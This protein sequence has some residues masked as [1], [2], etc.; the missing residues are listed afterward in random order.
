MATAA[1]KTAR[2]EEHTLNSIQFK[3]LP[4]IKI[5][6]FK[7]GK[8]RQEQE[9]FIADKEKLLQKQAKFAK[10]EQ[11]V[12]NK[13]SRLNCKIKE[14]DLKHRRLATEEEEFLGRQSEYTVKREELQASVKQEYFEK[15][16]DLFPRLTL[17]KRQIANAEK[18]IEYIDLKL[19]GVEKE[20]RSRDESP[21]ERESL[22]SKKYNLQL[23]QVSIRNSIEHRRRDKKEIYFE[24]DSL[25]R[26]QQ[27]IIEALKTANMTGTKIDRE[28][29]KRIRK[30]YKVSDKIEKLK[31]KI[32]K[33]NHKTTQLLFAVNDLEN[34]LL[35]LKETS[36]ETARTAIDT[37]DEQVA[38]D[39]RKASNKQFKAYKKQLKIYKKQFTF[40]KNQLKFVKR[41][42]KFQ[43]KENERLNKVNKS[44]LSKCQLLEKHIDLQEDVDALE[45]RGDNLRKPLSAYG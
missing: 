39:L 37:N 14:L 23:Q 41:I 6:D 27:R 42:T 16:K 10:I 13:N 11:K 21:H 1:K 28:H 29:A 32:D 7:L 20:L 31:G 35:N 4:E 2:K 5:L 43:S 3:G 19:R 22:L 17:L 45:V 25:L 34:I 44:L 26:E 33:Y 12:E 36:D 18:E 9:K 8:L 24:P 15:L 40:C 38:K 30:L